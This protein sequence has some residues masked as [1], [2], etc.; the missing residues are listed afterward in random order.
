MTTY[1]DRKRHQKVTIEIRADTK[2]L[3]NR[4]LAALGYDSIDALI[5]DALFE[6]E[7]S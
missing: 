3:I 1:Q 2:A 6:F 7:I 4:Q 5:N